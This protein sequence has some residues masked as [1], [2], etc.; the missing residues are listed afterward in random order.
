MITETLDFTL[1]VHKSFDYFEEAKLLN[2]S[3]FVKACVKGNKSA[4]DSFIIL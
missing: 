2:S 3:I 1:F 4:F